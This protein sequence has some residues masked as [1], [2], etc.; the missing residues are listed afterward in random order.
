MSLRC[1]RMVVLHPSGL[2]FT[3]SW[4]FSGA[5]PSEDFSGSKR[6][7][8]PLEMWHHPRNQQELKPEAGILKVY[9]ICKRESLHISL[10]RNKYYPQLSAAFNSKVRHINGGDFYICQQRPNSV[11]L[12][13]SHNTVNLNM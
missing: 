5:Q 3:L 8:H 11:S 13:D 1:L 7:V 10:W 12:R 2:E 4:D 6:F 9:K